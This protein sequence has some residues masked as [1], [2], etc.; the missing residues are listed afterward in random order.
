MDS[1]F[2]N[3]MA[4]TDDL[5]VTRVTKRYGQ[6]PAVLTNLS[7]TFKAGTATG[8]V[9]P[10]GSGKTTLLR[11][12][13]VTSFP[14]EGTIH[15]GKIDIHRHPH[16]YLHHVGIVHDESALPRYLNAVELLEY[17]LRA[18][19]LWTASSP[20]D[21]AALLDLVRLDERRDQLIGTYSSGMF[22]KTQIAMALIARPRVLLMDE[23]FRGLDTASLNAM[24]TLFQQRKA[25]GAVLVIA[26]HRQDMLDNLTDD[27]VNM[28]YH[29]ASR[30][31]ETPHDQ[32]P[33][34][35]T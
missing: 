21:I 31:V 10:N 12:L 22:K 32:T 13:S 17:T 9:G 11:L 7:H 28:Q 27:I 18:R 16:A 3:N 14:T 24:L 33:N 5:V 6:G 8:L 19:Q 1:V 30:K 25:E 29:E 4:Y 34:A 23:P 2:K 35:I 20:E 26:S 15:Y